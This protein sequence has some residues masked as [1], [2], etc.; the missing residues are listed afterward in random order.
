MVQQYLGG[1]MTLE[2][3]TY[4]KF[5]AGQII[6]H[7]NDPV[8][9]LY[10]VQSGQIEVF[11][12]VNSGPRILLGLIGSGEYLGELSVI[13]ENPFHSATAVALTVSEVIRIP[14]D[15]INEQL[16]DVPPWLV[17]LTRG[18]G[19]KLRRANEVLRRNGVVDDQLETAI[20]SVLENER[21]KNSGG[22]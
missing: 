22:K 16:K 14:V 2:K 1:V 18:L 6:F 13:S 17:A 21:K 5:K 9:A 20:Y 12:R 7:E 15:A 10:I 19:N 8:R 3:F 11:R 4:V